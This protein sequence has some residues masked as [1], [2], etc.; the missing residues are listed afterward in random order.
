MLHAKALDC[1]WYRERLGAGGEIQLTSDRNAQADLLSH[2]IDLRAM[3]LT[4]DISGTLA[5]SSFGM[6]YSRST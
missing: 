4:L 6:G 3:F 5:R 1:I 2:L